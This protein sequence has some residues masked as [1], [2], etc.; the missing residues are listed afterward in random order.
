VAGRSAKKRAKGCSSLFVLSQSA[1]WPIKNTKLQSEDS[2]SLGWKWQIGLTEN[3]NGHK[4][5]RL[6][7]N[8]MTIYQVN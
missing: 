7:I 8:R 6:N 3:E 4:K 2:R 5:G 1:A